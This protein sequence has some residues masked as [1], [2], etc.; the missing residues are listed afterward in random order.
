MKIFWLPDLIDWDGG[1]YPLGSESDPIQSQFEASL[2][3]R[4]TGLM[5][6]EGFIGRN[7]VVSCRRWWRCR[8][9]LSCTRVRDGLGWVWESLFKHCTGTVDP[10]TLVLIKCYE[11][12]EEM[13][14]WFERGFITFII[15]YSVICCCHLV[16]KQGRESCHWTIMRL[17]AAASFLVA[18]SANV[19]L[20]HRVFHP[21]LRDLPYARRASISFPP[22]SN[23]VMV[24]SPQLYDTLVA[25]SEML[26]TLQNTEGALYQLALEHEGDTSNALWDISSVKIVCLTI[27]YFFINTSCFVSVPSR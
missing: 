4:P 27:I 6:G 18:V 22:D 11:G 12:V 14:S 2:S 26:E 25:F 13:D 16:Q 3:T 21:S 1:N 10:H 7:L 24:P 8:N 17:I 5:G 19:N 20:Y 23:P 9:G 15:W